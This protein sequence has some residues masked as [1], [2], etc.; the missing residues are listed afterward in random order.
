MRTYTVQTG[1]TDMKLNLIEWSTFV[2]VVH[3]VIYDH[4]TQIH[5]FGGAKDF[6]PYMNACWV[7]ECDNESVGVLQEKLQ[8]I[9]RQFK[10][11][12]IAWTTGQTVF[13]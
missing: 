10:Q 5:F 9:R 1:N 11:N 8:V 2:D 4:S 3:S 6:S 13:L 12:S 7:F